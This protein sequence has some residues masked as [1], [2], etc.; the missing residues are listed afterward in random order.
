M[1]PA[2]SVADA[3]VAD[4]AAGEMSEAHALA[5]LRV[6]GLTPD[7]FALADAV[8]ALHLRDELLNKANAN[9]YSFLGI[10]ERFYSFDTWTAAAQRCEDDYEAALRVLARRQAQAVA[11]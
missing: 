4:L 11:S 7:P 10:P 8:K 9:P 3:I 1:T 5:E 2:L 6:K